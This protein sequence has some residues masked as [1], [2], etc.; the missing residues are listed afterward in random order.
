MILELV[1]KPAETAVSNIHYVLIN[2][3]A[4]TL[5]LPASP[6]VGTMVWVTPGN[7]LNNNVIARNGSNIMGLAEDM[8][9]DNAD[10]TAALRYINSSLGWR[11]L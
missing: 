9:L 5:A 3:S 1:S 2:G 10:A 4:S 7:V 11:L 8:T 6:A